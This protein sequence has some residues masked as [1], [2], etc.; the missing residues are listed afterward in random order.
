M[1]VLVAVAATTAV[2]VVVVVVVVVEEEEQERID[3]DGEQKVVVD[4]AGNGVLMAVVEDDGPE[5][6]EETGSISL[7]CRNHRL[8]N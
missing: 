6:V 5:V 3:V 2:V 4:E 8:T 7:R 1:V